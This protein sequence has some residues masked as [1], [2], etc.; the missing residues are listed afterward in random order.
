[1]Y[2]SIKNLYTQTNAQVKIDQFFTEPFETT[3]GVRQGD[4]M[5]PVLFNILINDL[6]KEITN[7]NCGVKIQDRNISILVYADDIVLVAPDP[8]KLQQMLDLIYNWCSKHRL[9][10]NTDKSQVIHFRNKH[11]QQTIA[12]FTLGD[13]PLQL[14]DKY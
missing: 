10:I 13:S 7:L 5:S 4:S 3:S 14:V 2:T 6:I 12:K 9:L 1:M 8:N 11:V